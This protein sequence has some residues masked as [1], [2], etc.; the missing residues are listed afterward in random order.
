MSYLLKFDLN[1]IYQSINN[2]FK[3]KLQQI[4][5]D[6]LV[7]LILFSFIENKWLF[8]EKLCFKSKNKQYV[9]DFGF[10]GLDSLKFYD[11][12][13]I[14]ILN[15]ELYHSI[16][17]FLCD[18]IISDGGIIDC[19]RINVRYCSYQHIGTRFDS[20]TSI[21]NKLNVL[22]LPSFLT[23]PLQRIL[24]EVNFFQRDLFYTSDYETRNPF[25]VFTQNDHKSTI[26]LNQITGRDSIS[27]DLPI[28]H[29]LLKI[30]GLLE[31]AY[32]SFLYPPSTEDIVKRF[33]TDTVDR[34][35]QNMGVIIGM[36]YLYHLYIIILWNGF[37]D[38][39]YLKPL[40]GTLKSCLLI[41]Q[42]IKELFE[43]IFEIN[44]DRILVK[45]EE[46]FGTFSEY[47]EKLYATDTVVLDI[48]MKS[49][50]FTDIRIVTQVKLLIMNLWILIQG[51]N[52]EEEVEAPSSGLINIAYFN[53]FVT[54]N[55]LGN[56]ISND[57]KNSLQKNGLLFKSED[58]S[59][60]ISHIIKFS[61]EVYYK[62]IMNTSRIRNI[63]RCIILYDSQEKDHF[64]N[65]F[66]DT[67]NLYEDI[68]KPVNLLGEI[69]DLFSLYLYIEKIDYFLFKTEFDNEE[70]EEEPKVASSESI[71]KLQMSINLLGYYNDHLSKDLNLGLYIWFILK[72]NSPEFNT[73]LVNNT[74][75]YRYS[76][77]PKTDKFKQLLFD[78]IGIPYNKF[79]HISLKREPGNHFKLVINGKHQ[80]YSIDTFIIHLLKSNDTVQIE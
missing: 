63:D 20:K 50:L 35:G 7:T 74:E 15:V 8:K 76:T 58:I 22:I 11:N 79:D 43:L 73:N 56:L 47:N 60:N 13:I 9:N 25:L 61:N 16:R 75:Y 5:K 62:Q 41:V 46:S 70:K 30:M 39:I 32:Y 10:I 65:L 42:Y 45:L 67:S 37:S 59:N 57:Y 2:I 77:S 27:W 33:L 55:S 71:D 29:P 52:K 19:D 53:Q 26:K 4:D 48:L 40:F 64:I 3:I 23:K 1:N 80:F 6:R 18:S 24:G 34:Y 38:I 78:Q 14:I 69:D 21:F 28:E 44:K 72:T 66:R 17:C 68:Y 12:N 51:V 36:E 31:L 54:R 49:A